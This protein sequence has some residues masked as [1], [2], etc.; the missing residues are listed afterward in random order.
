MGT[1]AVRGIGVV[2]VK[3]V[4]I[5]ESQRSRGALQQILEAL[6]PPAG[7]LRSGLVAGELRG[8]EVIRVDEEAILATNHRSFLAEHLGVEENAAGV[9]DE[10][11]A[12]SGARRRQRGFEG[13]LGALLTE[14][15]ARE[16]VARQAVAPSAGVIDEV[17]A[18]AHAGLVESVV[19]EQ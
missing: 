11:V 6:S 18:G 15:Q 14:S 1:E 5:A 17:G 7:I 9:G 19:P 10:Q 16:Q 12:G 8:L 2:S 13:T 4:E 3:A